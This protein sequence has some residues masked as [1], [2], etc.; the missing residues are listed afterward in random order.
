[1]NEALLF[2]CGVA[3]GYL[4]GHRVG[5]MHALAV[6]Q[7]EVSDVLAGWKQLLENVK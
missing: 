2:L 4:L 7:A 5:Y 1:M 3:V 6:I